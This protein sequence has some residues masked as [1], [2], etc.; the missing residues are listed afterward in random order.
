MSDGLRSVLIVVVTCVWAANF[1][2]PIFKKDYAPSPELNVAF[3]AI[4][5]VLTAS[6]RAD[7]P[8]DGPG[9]P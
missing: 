8:D 1:I 5:G 6:Y 7:P 9:T 3:M 4:I 2:A